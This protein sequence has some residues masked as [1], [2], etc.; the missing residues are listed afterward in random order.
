MYVLPTPIDWK[1]EHMARFGLVIHVCTNEFICI[2]VISLYTIAFCIATVSVLA[3]GHE[4]LTLLQT[5]TY[6]TLN[7]K[8]TNKKEN[9][10]SGRISFM[11]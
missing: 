8:D 9:P 10:C 1:L 2:L 7:P 5:L 11:L 4:A 6:P 3:K